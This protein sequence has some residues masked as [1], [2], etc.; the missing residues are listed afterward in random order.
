M[1]CGVS[2]VPSKPSY[3]LD[4]QAIFSADLGIDE[5]Q[6]FIEAFC[7]TDRRIFVFF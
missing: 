4:R 5:G 7:G 3:T 6:F 2:Y 1:S